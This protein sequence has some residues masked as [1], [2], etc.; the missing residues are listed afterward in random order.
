MNIQ[1]DAF[2]HFIQ[3]KKTKRLFKIIF[4]FLKAHGISELKLGDI[5]STYR[6]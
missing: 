1:V 6:H 3:Q 2:L 5:D 4:D